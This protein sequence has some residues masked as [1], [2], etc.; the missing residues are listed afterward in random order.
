[1]GHGPTGIIIINN[2]HCGGPYEPLSWTRIQLCS[3]LYGQNKKRTPPPQRVYNR[4]VR[5]MDIDRQEQGDCVVLHDGQGYQ[6]SSCLTIVKV[7]VGLEEL[8]YIAEDY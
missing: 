6:H 5:Q 3:G 8:F 7:F 1:M 2:L 4:S